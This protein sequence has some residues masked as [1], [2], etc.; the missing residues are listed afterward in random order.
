MPARNLEHVFLTKCDA[1]PDAE[2]AVHRAALKEAQIIATPISILDD[3][4]LHEV[5]RLLNELKA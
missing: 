5:R 3:E 4:R 2:L 1:V